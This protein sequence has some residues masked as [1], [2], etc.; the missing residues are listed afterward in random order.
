MS[1]LDVAWMLKKD[2]KLKWYLHMSSKTIF[3]HTEFSKKVTLLENID[4]IFL[5]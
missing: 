5:C 2:M 1:S 4:L 3:Q